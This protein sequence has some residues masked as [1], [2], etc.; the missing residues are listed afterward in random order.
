M[1]S[2]EIH[3]VLIDLADATVSTSGG[4]AP[5]LARL[6]AAG[7]PVPPGFV[8]P[9]RAY[10]EAIAGVDVRGPDDVADAVRR[11]WASLWSQRA[12]QY[13]QR[14]HGARLADRPAMAVL[15][16]RLVDADVAGVLFTGA[17]L[18]VEASWGLGESVVS[19]TVTPDS[20][21]VIG[22][23]IS[24][25]AVG[26]KDSRIDRDGTQVVTRK[27]PPAVRDRPCLM[28]IRSEAEST[29]V[30]STPSAGAPTNTGASRRRTAKGEDR[31]SGEG[32]AQAEQADELPHEYNPALQES[33]HREKTVD[34]SVYLERG[35]LTGVLQQ[36]LAGPVRECEV[37]ACVQ[38]L[39]DPSVHLGSHRGVQQ[40]AAPPLG[41]D[42]EGRPGLGT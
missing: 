17:T 26:R 39:F 25:R 12:V 35:D 2:N 13:R 31:H 32:S 9:T 33:G 40:S 28:R 16:Q 42:L 19:G 14:Q 7:L 1:Y 24:E 15:V 27:V 36:I 6:L 5:P 22:G 29:R 18:R 10:E 11:C 8:V 21:V 41:A 4:K 23:A 37:D 34:V 38:C 20:W 3:A 30:K